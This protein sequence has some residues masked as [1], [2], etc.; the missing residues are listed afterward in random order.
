MRK[1]SLFDDGSASLSESELEDSNIN[2]LATSGLISG[3]GSLLDF[4]G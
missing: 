2:Q 4:W 3:E 1:P